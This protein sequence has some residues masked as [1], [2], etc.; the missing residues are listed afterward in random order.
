MLLLA[1]A[2][3]LVLQ[4]DV[5]KSAFRI[6][7]ERLQ[8]VGWHVPPSERQQVFCD[9]DPYYW[10]SYANQMVEQG[11]WRVR[12]TDADNVPMGRPV[13]WSQSMSWLM[14][15]A[16]AVARQVEPA[17]WPVA[18]ERGAVWINPFL[19]GLLA[20]TGLWLLSR[21]MGWMPA[22]AWFAGMLGAGDL[23]WN[24]HA[25]RPDHQSLHVLFATLG[26][27]LL[28]LGGMGWVRAD[29]ATIAETGSACW[30]PIEPPAA[31]QARR[32]L[33]GS[34]IVG[35]MGLWTGAT[36]QLLTIG[37]S[38]AAGLFLVLNRP[39]ARDGL[40]FDASLWRLWARAGAL[41]GLAFFLVEYAGAWPGI[42]LEVNSP[43]HAFSWWCAG[44]ALAA[45]D[46][47]RGAPAG[48]RSSAL[49]AACAWA[50]GAATLP[51]AL[52]AGPTAWHAMKDPAMMRLHNFIQEFYTYGNFTHGQPWRRFALGYGFWP[53]LVP[54]AV[55]LGV[56]RWSRNYEW[57]LL[58]LG[59][60]LATAMGLLSWQ[61][62]RWLPFF[63][64]SLLLLLAVV[65]AVLGRHARESAGCRFAAW[66]LLA[67]TLGQSL[68]FISRQH[69]E[70]RTLPRIGDQVVQELVKPIL[71][72]HLALQ[73]AEADPR[74][75]MRMLCEPD[76]A[77]PLYYFGG[78]RTVT[79]FY[80]ENIAG[81][82]DAAAFFN[83]TDGEQAR[84]I[85]LRRG[86]THVMLPQGAELA[87]ICQFVRDG[88]FDRTAAAATLLGRVTAGVSP[89]WWQVDRDLSRVGASKY[90]YGGGFVNRTMIVYRLVP[91]ATDEPESGRVTAHE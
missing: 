46:R 7:E 30:R 60:A 33:I 21:R 78:I 59:F 72:K 19:H 20:A 6:Y 62:V 47:W 87:D 12:H 26:A 31:K 28:A 1:A 38:L 53:L 13:H 90:R 8:P 4:A 35:G 66:A 54:A 22:I 75:T 37:A 42:R 16:G 17:A 80:W 86:L 70:I 64:S 55:G 40:L 36:V 67:A 85:A 41:T 89:R 34:G 79:S 91:L 23:A 77:P 3:W 43:L 49:V 24:F 32:Y 25:L 69:R 88:R 63:A 58:W 68:W 27:L 29:G 73:L 44:E 83:D 2:G 57:S 76:L 9:N 14:V 65:L 71:I 50:A 11:S 61:Q 51:A 5:W 84:T 15:A 39:A 45:L 18:M 48:H 52:A 10:L 56:P 74:H 82:R 81:L